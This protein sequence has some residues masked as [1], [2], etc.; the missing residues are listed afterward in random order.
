[1]VL[2]SLAFLTPAVIALVVGAADLRG[3]ST[4]HVS[5]TLQVWLFVY[6]IASVVLV[7]LVWLAMYWD[8]GTGRNALGMAFNWLAGLLAIFLACPWLIVGQIILTQGSAYLVGVSSGQLAVG[9]VALI[10]SYLL[11]VIVVS[12][13]G[14]VVRYAM[15]KTK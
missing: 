1:M 7:P 3:G 13:V 11:V 12:R 14:Y 2:A 8:D 9:I 10:F 15:L 6:G 5:V 4:A